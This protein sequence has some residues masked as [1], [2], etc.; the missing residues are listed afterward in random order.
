[1]GVALI[2]LGMAAPGQAASGGHEEGSR[3]SDEAIP[4]QTDVFPERPRMLIEFGEPFLRTGRLS[5]GIKLPT[6]QVWRPALW[7]FGT[8]RTGFQTFDPGAARFAEWAHRLDLFANLRLSAT[9][10]LVV[11]IRPLDEFGSVGYNFRPSTVN[12]GWQRDLNGDIQALFFEG[13]IGEM[14]PF[15]DPDDFK[16]LDIGFSVG[17]QD[18]TLQEGVLVQDNFDLVGLTRNTLRPSGTSNLRLTGVYGWNHLHRA[19]NT[20][21]PTAQLFGLFTEIDAPLST[22]NIDLAYVKASTL[23]GD[24]FY[25]GISGVQ[26]I[27]GVNT[28]IRVNASL[29]VDGDTPATS[30]GVLWLNEISWTPHGTHNLLYFNSFWGIERFSSAARS[31]SSGGPLGR[32]GI[33]FAAVGLGRYSAALDNRADEAAGGSLGYQMFFARNRR[34]LIVEAGGRKDTNGIGAGAAAV[35]MRL[36]QA[37]GRRMVLQF[38]GFATVRQNRDAAYGARIETL[39]KF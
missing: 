16:S 14:F 39:V 31:P 6:G 18:L 33:L 38:D 27:K 17:R 36:Q 7:V 15:L 4:L 2:L 21:D 29:P 35:G 23:T 32:T 13:D 12:H 28:S 22:L 25:A 30:R 10:R 8:Y 9:E 20:E 11:G 24:A 3:I 26:R 34:Q 37:V 1:M 5:R 19:N